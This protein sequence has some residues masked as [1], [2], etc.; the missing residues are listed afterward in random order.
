MVGFGTG[1]R[2]SGLKPAFSLKS[3]A[4]VSKLKFWN[5]LKLQKKAP[6]EKEVRKPGRPPDNTADDKHRMLKTIAD[7]KTIQLRFYLK[8]HHQLP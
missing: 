2:K 8:P 6:R 7:C 3:K 4:T 1:F 5:S